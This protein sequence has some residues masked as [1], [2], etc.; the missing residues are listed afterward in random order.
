MALST[1]AGI[2]VRCACWQCCVPVVVAAGRLASAPSGLHAHRSFT[3]VRRCLEGVPPDVPPH[4]RAATVAAL[5]LNALALVLRAADARAALLDLPP[6]DRAALLGHV[7]RAARLERASNAAA[8]ALDAIGSCA[9]SAEL[10]GELL[11]RGVLAHLFTAMF[12]CA[13]PVCLLYRLRCRLELC[14]L[15]RVIRGATKARSARLPAT[16]VVHCVLKIRFE[17]VPESTYDSTQVWTGT[18]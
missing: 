14:C 15:E 4:D 7:L 10:Q 3:V 1:R 6:A 5:T 18:S 11:R 9:A 13:A 16:S 17:R 8:G 2:T 12:K